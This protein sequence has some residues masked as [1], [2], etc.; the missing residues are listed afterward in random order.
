VSARDPVGSLWEATAP[1]DPAEGALFGDHRADVCVVGAGFT[2]LAAALN[3]AQAGCSV[4]VLDSG[5]AGYGASGRNGGQVLPGF[6]WDPDQLV[7][8]YGRER[9]E[10]IAAFAGAAPTLVYHLIERHGIEC[11]LR[12]CG[13]LNAAVDDTA[14]DRQASRADQWSRRG[15]PVRLVDRE[16]AA[17]LLG[18]E[19]YRGALLDERAGALNPLAYARG[20]AAAAQRAGARI[21]GSS[22]V[23]SLVRENGGWR[24]STDV[25]TIVAGQVI[26]ATNA[27]TG[28]LWPGLA[29]EVIPIHS[30]QVAT[31]PLPD[32]VRRSILPGG[33]VVSD[34]QRILLYFRLDDA[35]RL[36]MGGRGSLGETNRDTL[37]RFVEDAAQRLFPAIG[38]PRW[39][40]RWSGKVA[41]TADY[42]PRLHE[43][44]P[45]LRV[46][47]GYNGRG[48]A[49]ATALG[50]ALG[51]WTRIGNA[52]ALP[53]PP[54]PLKPLPFHAFRRPLLEGVTAYYRLRDRMSWRGS[55]AGGAG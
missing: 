16:E 30:L 55:R 36:V 53:L 15:A 29:Q 8:T 20:L 34:T 46:C 33:H 1:P 40:F 19:R 5:G 50:T 12:R 11:G 3:L 2:G 39:E 42:M 23:R 28:D 13:W 25:G 49:M 31:A 26:L 17:A 4:V 47:L 24:L 43:L 37:Y 51:D 54:Q 45:G 9:G 18:T 32:A 38:R 35:G 44:A 21:H 10:A 6:K 52:E 48:V 7:A 41:L 14:F 22:Q 27:Y